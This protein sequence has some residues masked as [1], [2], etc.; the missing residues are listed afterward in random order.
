[1]PPTWLATQARNFVD[2]L[3][4]L[5]AFSRRG[6]GAATGWASGEIYCVLIARDHVVGHNYVPRLGSEQGLLVVYDRNEEVRETRERVQSPLPRIEGP[7]FELDRNGKKRL[8]PFPDVA[9]A[10]VHCA[11]NRGV[12]VVIRSLSKRTWENKAKVILHQNFLKEKR[13]FLLV[14]SLIL[15]LNESE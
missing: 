15:P 9:P 6:E 1:M 12:T 13:A 2:W 11:A 3:F 4:V 10:R 7:S 8:Q 5:R 14:F